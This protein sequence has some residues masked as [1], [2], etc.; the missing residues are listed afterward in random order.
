V[1]LPLLDGKNGLV[2]GVANEFSLAAFVA[3]KASEQGASLAFNFLP[4]ASSGGAKAEK[5]VRRVVDAFNP[6]LLMPCDLN[7]EESTDAFFK[8]LQQRM[9]RIDFM[10]HSV[11]WAPLSDILCRTID[12][13]R[14]GFL[15]AME[16]SVFSFLSAVRRA[17]DLM[18]T[19]GSIVT[20][21]YYGAE[22]VVDGYNLMGICKAALESAVRYAASEM[23]PR[24]IRVNAISA[25][26]IKTLSASAVQGLEGM[27]NL[28][29]AIAPMRRNIT[30]SDVAGTACWLAS[31]SSASITGTVIHADCGYGIMGG[32]PFALENLGKA[33]SSILKGS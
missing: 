3:A 27:L 31:D 17:S 29:E 4:D 24:G 12:V 28:H 11:A 25:G 1:P 30:G 33:A 32:P 18:P 9:P 16:T 5:R 19:G 10:V 13:S 21:T 2:L 6:I 26:P 8:E 7:Q 20:M 14:A 22:K 15:E 23:G